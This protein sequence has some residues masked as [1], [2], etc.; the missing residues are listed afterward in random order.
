MLEGLREEFEKIGLEEHLCCNYQSKKER[1]VAVVSFFSAGIKNN[2][3]CLFVMDEST[4]EEVVRAFERAGVDVKEYLRT[5]QLELLKFEEMYLKDGYFDP[6][7]IL[8]RIRG[9]VKAAIKDGYRG[10][11]FAV[12]VSCSLRKLPDC[13]RLIE[14]E[15]KINKLLSQSRI[16]ALCLYNERKFPPKTLIDV[17]YTH[18][19]VILHGS[20]YD[21]PEFLRPEDFLAKGEVTQAIYERVKETVIERIKLEKKHK[22]AQEQTKRDQEYLQLLINRMPIGLIVLDRDFKVRTWNPAATKILGFTPEET[23][24]KHPYNF[25]VPKEV[26]PRTDE[27]WRRLLAGDLTAHSINENITKD[28]RR[29]VCEWMN[30]P[31]RGPDGGILGVLSM[32]QDITER[33]RAEEALRSSEERYRTL[34]ETMNEGLGYLDENGVILHVNQ[35][36]CEMVGY[37]RDEIIGRRL[38]DFLDDENRKIFE[39]NFKKALRGER[40]V[41]E[42]VR[43]R[44]DGGKVYTLTS[45]APMIIDGKIKGTFAVI[46][47]ITRLKKIESSLRESELKYSTIV[48][49]GPEGVVIIQDGIIKFVNRRLSEITGIKVEEYLGNSYLNFIAPEYQELAAERYTKRMSGVKVPD[50]YEIELIGRDG[51]RIPFEIIATVID[52]EGRPADMVILRDITERKNME[53]KAREMIY[54]LYGISIGECYLV[55]SI[56]MAVRIFVQ[57]VIHDVPGLCISREKPENLI[58]KGVPEDKILV[59]SSVPVKGFESIDGLQEVSMKISDFIQKNLRS[60]V[61]LGGLEY[62]ISRSGFDAVYRFLQEKRFSFMEASA[63]LLIPLDL[64][65]LS[66]KE[67]AQ[68]TAEIKLLGR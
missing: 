42:L 18:P 1:N 10:L 6:D 55:P 54:A 65:T 40:C 8:E 15:T 24:G 61:L 22:L 28:G 31:L 48:E 58:Q 51:R 29:I 27:I 62:L 57:L 67:R 60:V 47:D 35:K 33:Q 50:R 64:N 20:V 13:E 3:K 36:Y 26:Q 63:N 37:S 14:Y 11:R 34:V 59:L 49:K 66:E 52:Y 41:Y 16:S 23:L 39:E 21:N 53:K 25:L 17:F 12:E 38:T 4:E 44:K 32:F 2:E 9:A 56:D 30:T 7:R 19:K 5:R 43:L 68:L 46:T 45:T